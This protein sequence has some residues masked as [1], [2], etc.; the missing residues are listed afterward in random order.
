MVK[1]KSVDYGEKA[2]TLLF[3]VIA[4]YMLIGSF[5]FSG[6]AALFPQVTAVI[7]TVFAGALLF[8]EYVPEPF[9]SF[10]A[11]VD[12]KEKNIAGEKES[13]EE[14]TDSIHDEFKQSPEDEA[15]EIHQTT[16]YGREISTTGLNRSVLTVLVGLYIFF[17]YLV[18]MLWVTPFFVMAY[19]LYTRLPWY[20]TVGLPIL[21]FLI[22]Q[23]FMNVV[24][25]PV[26][27]GWLHATGWL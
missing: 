26:D 10:L 9:Y 6:T 27:E 15:E 12:V 7:V 23:T 2:V 14:N 4:L 5:E 22:A 17:S 8:R 11:D 19:C 3:L 13:S 20:L 16:I 18:G 25:I 21:S 1:T 24:Y